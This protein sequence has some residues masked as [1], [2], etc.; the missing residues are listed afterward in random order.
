MNVSIA[1]IP[2]SSTSTT[3]SG[4]I[5]VPQTKLQKAAQEFE[6]ILLQ[7]WMEKMNHSFLGS[8]DSQDAAHDTIS[9]LGTQ[10]VCSALAARGGVGIA[11]MIVRQLQ[12]AAD[13]VAGGSGKFESGDRLIRAP[14]SADKQDGP[15]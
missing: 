4:R 12:P 8:D 2:D 15:S 10:A 11:R 1:K 13:S 7:D 9:S 3:Q 14:N 5:V 6:A